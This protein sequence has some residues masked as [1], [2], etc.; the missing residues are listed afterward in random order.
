MIGIDIAP[1]FIR[2]AQEEEQNDPRGIQYMPGDGRD[3]PFG[4]GEFDF[5]TAFM[6]LM[7][8]PD[9]RRVLQQVFRVVRSGGFFQFSILHPCFV[10]PASQ[11]H[12]GR[13]W[14]LLCR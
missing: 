9:Q 12:S 2:H 4:D 10:P 8:M 6:S 13:E 7:D 3:L 14:R 11:D 5:V 1:T